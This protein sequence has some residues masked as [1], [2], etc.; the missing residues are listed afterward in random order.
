MTITF[1]TLSNQKYLTFST[2]FF[3][4]EYLAKITSSYSLSL[5]P[6]TKKIQRK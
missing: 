3:S 6:N 2:V 4:E 5:G 1:I